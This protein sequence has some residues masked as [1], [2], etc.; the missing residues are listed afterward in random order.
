MFFNFCLICITEYFLN[1]PG[2]IFIC[3]GLIVSNPR[4]NS[5]PQKQPNSIEED[6][7]DTLKA[8]LPSCLSQLRF[9]TNP[10]RFVLATICF[11]SVYS[12]R[13]SPVKLNCVFVL[14]EACRSHEYF[15]YMKH[16][17]STVC[18]TLP[19]VAI[20]TSSSSRCRDG[21]TALLA[22][23]YNLLGLI[24]IRQLPVTLFT[25]SFFRFVYSY[26]NLYSPKKN[27]SNTKAQ[28]YKHKYKQSENNDQVYHSS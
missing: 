19:T 6:T 21:R 20:V 18:V 24:N 23:H 10:A 5:S 17:S 7:C 25:F 22:L 13:I 8:I 2:V 4:L 9:L 1:L 14:A 12:T 11:T 26:I 27:G 16:D 15:S 28:Q 3:F